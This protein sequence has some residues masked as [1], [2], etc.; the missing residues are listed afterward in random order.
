MKSQVLHTVWCNITVEATGE[1][2]TWSLLGVKGLK[3]RK[4]A[5]F[6]LMEVTEE[7][8]LLLTIEKDTIG[9]FQGKRL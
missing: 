9:L 5:L 8:K 7:Y 6:E 2:W 1:I 4:N 3:G